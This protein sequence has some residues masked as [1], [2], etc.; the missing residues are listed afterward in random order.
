MVVCGRGVGF[1]QLE[2]HI[3]LPCH[4]VH[5]P[6]VNVGE[7]FFPVLVGDAEAV[8]PAV[9]HGR[10][11]RFPNATAG[12]GLAGLPREGDLRLALPLAVYADGLMGGKNHVGC[13][14]RVC[15]HKDSSR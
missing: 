14:N 15:M 5:F 3:G 8:R 13:K 11:F 6:H 7:D 12:N 4:Q 1:L 9:V 2:L 10:E